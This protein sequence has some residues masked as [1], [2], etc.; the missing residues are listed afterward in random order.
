MLPQ[1]IFNKIRL[2]LLG[3]IFGCIIAGWFHLLPPQQTLFLRERLFYTLFAFLFVLEAQS[4][5]LGY[6]F[7]LFLAA[8]LTIGA[9]FLPLPWR[10]LQE[11]GI[12]YGGILLFLLL[13]KKRRTP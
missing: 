13:L 8:L 11:A 9:A 2:V 1:K 10:H 5:P 7:Q 4:A 12:F 3:L 6:R